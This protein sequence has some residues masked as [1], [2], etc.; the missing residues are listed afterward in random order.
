MRSEVGDFGLSG[1]TSCHRHGL[2]CGEISQIP[3]KVTEGRRSPCYLTLPDRSPEAACLTLGVR[4]TPRQRLGF[5]ASLAAENGKHAHERGYRG[6]K[7]SRVR[8]PRVKNFTL[9][10]DEKTG[11]AYAHN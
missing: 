9:R 7:P 11:D 2:S 6:G 5:C 10:I 3:R 8:D 1:L 4:P